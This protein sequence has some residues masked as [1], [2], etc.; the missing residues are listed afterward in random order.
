M[1]SSHPAPSRRTHVQ[2]AL[3]VRNRAEVGLQAGSCIFAN[4]SV[5]ADRLAIITGPFAK[6]GSHCSTHSA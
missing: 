2:C 3:A 5:T 6:R 4:I 1:S